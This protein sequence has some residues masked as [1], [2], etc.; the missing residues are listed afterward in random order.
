MSKCNHQY[1]LDV[2]ISITMARIGFIG[3]GFVGKAHADDFE[4]RGISVV[5]YAKEEPYTGNRE[6]IAGCDIVFIAV[7]TPTTL[8]G[9]DSSIV[10]SVIGLTCPGA[11]VVVKSTMVPGST[12]RLAEQFPDRFVMHAPEFLREAHAAHDAAHPERVIV[13]ITSDTEEH[14]TRAQEV[15]SVLPTA[16]FT[17]VVSARTAELVKYAGNAFLYVKVVYAN[18]LYDLSESLGVSYEDLS[19]MLGADSRIG[20]SHLAVVHASGHTDKSGRGAGGHCFIKDFEAL[21]R[22]YAEQ[23]VD[24]EGS[25]VLDALVGKNNALL[26]ASGKDLDLLREVY[27]P[28]PT[29]L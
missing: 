29:A 6:A 16:P 25:G 19:A 13:G 17:R 15:L 2:T 27:G 28:L 23:L 12:E 20:T 3:Q 21:R 24:P 8:Q 26:T 22:L 9:F 11:T 7:P 10:E 1:L 4:S 5:R 14:R 18:M